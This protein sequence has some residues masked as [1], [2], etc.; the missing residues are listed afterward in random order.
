MQK[1]EFLHTYL[2]CDWN[3]VP[4]LWLSSHCDQIWVCSL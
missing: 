2:E 4:S 3:P 1:R